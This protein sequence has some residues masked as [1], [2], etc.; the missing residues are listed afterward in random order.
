M[1]LDTKKTHTHILNLK[2]KN[3]IDSDDMLKCKTSFNISERDTY[4]SILMRH[5]TRGEKDKCI[6]LENARQTAP[7]YA[8]YIYDRL[9]IRSS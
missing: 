1:Y 2:K 4:I 9:Y 6:H 7:T 5:D 3:N 8:I